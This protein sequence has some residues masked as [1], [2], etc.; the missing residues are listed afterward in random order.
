MKTQ[1]WLTCGVGIVFLG[2]YGATAAPSI[3]ELFDD[4]LE[5]QLVA[6]TW[7]I[8]HP[9]GYPL[10]I[11]VGGLWSRL[12]FP[13]GNWAWRMNLL[14]ALTAAIAMAL[15][16]R[17]GSQLTPTHQGRPHAWAGLAAAMTYGLGPI[18]WSQATV[19]E[20]Y[21]LHA[22]FVIA[23]LSLTLYLVPPS[24]PHPFT[25]SALCFLLGLSLTHHRT[26]L[27]LLPALLFYLWWQAPGL[28]RPRWMWVQWAGALL[29]PLLLYLFLPL[30]AALGAQ[31][32]HGS[33]ANT[34]AGFWDHVLARQYTG[35]F[36]ENPLAIQRT[37]L[38]WFQL[39]RSQMGW[40]A[41]LFGLAGMW[42]LWQAG[43]T[44]RPIWLLLL[45]TLF[46]N[47]LFALFYQTHDG[48][49]FLLPALL[50]FALFTGAGMGWISHTLGRWPRLVQGGQLFGIILLFIGIGR[51]AAVNRSQAWA[52]HDYAVALAKV[53]FPP[54]SQVVGLEGE[55][56]A[57]RYMQQAEGLGRQA[58]PVVADDPARRWQI[59][60]ALVQAGQPTY[61]TR[62]LD[63]LAQRYSFSGEGPLVRVWPRGQAQVGSP[64]IRV[65]TSLVDGQLLLEGY[66]LVK[67]DQ[68]GGPALRIALYWR[69]QTVL[70]QTLKL[71]LRVQRLDGTPVQWPDGQAVQED[72]FPL[73]LVAMTPTWLPGE[74]VRDVH[75]L[76]I[77]TSVVGQPAHLQVLLYDAETIVEAGLWQVDLRW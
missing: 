7:S 60:E 27:L 11:L 72:H 71:S 26:S 37:W 8:A 19:A 29:A 14:S 70:T 17:L 2:L 31:D 1:I 10:Y 69:P 25:L 16:F 64:T 33:Y 57:L 5:F 56:T 51:G 12:L 44:T 4:S 74:L 38:D 75:Y 15:L 41:L 55:M 34:W 53:D 65:E 59:V 3:V 20:V 67:L 61:L 43:R 52:V 21:T 77:P 47:G 76:P 68:A 46:T 36:A 32:L 13:F 66:D 39:W 54:N 9:T 23:L 30:R 18:W 58:T 6:P 63:E 22:L 62:E 73:R 50:A 40:P 24:S 42:W 48:E 49:V 35:F 28:W 45:L